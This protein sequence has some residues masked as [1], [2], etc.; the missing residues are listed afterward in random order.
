MHRQFGLNSR[1]LR[2]QRN[3]GISNRI[4]RCMEF[5]MRRVRNS[6]HPEI[7]V[8]RGWICRRRKDVNMTTLGFDYHGSHSRIN[9]QPPIFH[10]GR[11]STLE[12]SK[13]APSCEFFS[14][15]VYMFLDYLGYDF[16]VCDEIDHLY[17]LR[18]YTGNNAR[19]ILTPRGYNFLYGK[20]LCPQV[21]LFVQSFP[22]LERNET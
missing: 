18:V 20:L 15:N 14:Q 11:T 17:H 1:G 8:R 2:H 16:E 21:E 10:R 22:R 9:P 7:A 4:A 19:R 6:E 12:I 3:T 13:R 5:Q